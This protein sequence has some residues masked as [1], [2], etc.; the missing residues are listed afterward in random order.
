M[1][2]VLSQEDGRRGHH[3]KLDVGDGY[4]SP[5]CL[6]LGILKHD[7]VLGDPICLRTILMHICTKGDHVNGME[8]AAVGI[9]KG[10]DFEGRHLCVEGVGILEIVVPYLVDRLTKELGGAML[11]RLVPGVVVEVGLVG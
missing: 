10:H 8:T 1:Q 5:L 6:L 7:D 4:A 3:K 11:G 2:E 9:K